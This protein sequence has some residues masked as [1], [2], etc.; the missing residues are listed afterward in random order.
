[1]R[2]G[3]RLKRGHCVFVLACLVALLHSGSVSAQVGG[4]PPTCFGREATIVG[5]DGDDTIVGTPRTDVIVGRDGVDHIRG[6]GGRDYIC[7][8]SNGP[9]P[10]PGDSPSFEHLGGG[11]GNDRISGG[12]GFDIVS[13]GPGAD[14]IRLGGNP[15]FLPCDDPDD[16]V[17]LV[18]AGFG[19]DG[20]DVLRGGAGLDD[21][22][23]GR[24]A[25][26]LDGGSG[27]D[28]LLGG[29]GDDVLNGGPDGDGVHGGRGHD[30]GFGAAGNDLWTDRES[31]AGN[32]R[33]SGGAGDDSAFAGRGRDVLH[34]GR[35]RD[36]LAGGT[37]DDVLHGGVD[38]D[39]LL[40][41]RGD[42]ALDG[43]RGRDLAWYALEF[44]ACSRGSVRVDLAAGRASG[45]QGSDR[46]ARIEGA[47]G[48]GKR[49]V[50]LGNARA[51][52]FGKLSG[53]G[54][55]IFHGRGGRD[56][57]VHPRCGFGGCGSTQI[58][59]DLTAGRARYPHVVPRGVV[60]LRSIENAQGSWEDD[61]LIGNVRRNVL[62]GSGGDDMILG[63]GGDDELIGDGDFF[64]GADLL[65]GGAG[66]DRLFGG[67]AA[68]DLDGGE[69]N[70]AND[71]GPDSD[72][73]VRPSSPVAVNCETT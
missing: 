24:G 13:G 7:G 53:G 59:V 70:N 63:R 68:D 51:N 64:P 36:E 56:T 37:G 3:S 45:G 58:I 16:C 60:E 25:D 39:A 17:P 43:G 48:G 46:L 15:F 57:L 65:R 38:R 69:G 18:D 42:D 32:D 9:P 71:G 6:R 26:L 35:G 28:G 54:S 1:M 20:D 31:T 21:L 40:G 34:G 61:R 5:T 49:D 2:R 4:D 73:C 10:T 8:E 12:P 52:F 41:A 50:F 30:V 29:R 33:F 23:G 11:P 47:I 66:A 27:D 19:G 67:G 44:C 55:G 62:V 72:R 14:R 22:D